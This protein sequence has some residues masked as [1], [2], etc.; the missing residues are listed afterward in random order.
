MNKI[1]KYSIL[2]YRPSYLLEE[3]VN[4][5]VLFF[6]LEDKKAVFIHPSKLRRITQFYPD[7]NLSTIRKY[8]AAFNQKVNKLNISSDIESFDSFIES[9]LLLKDASNLYFSTVKSNQ[10]IDIAK[11][12]EYYYRLYFSVYKGKTQRVKK[13]ETYLKK[14]F[15]KQLEEKL[16]GDKQRLALF[17]PK[18]SVKNTISNTEF[19]LGWQN[20]TTNL[21][22][23]LSFDLMDK[24]NFQEKSFR[25]YGELNQLKT[26]AEEQN[27]KV[28]LVL[29]KPQEKTLFEHYDNAIKVLEDIQTP[30]KIIEEHQL[31][32]YIESAIYDVKPLE[33]DYLFQS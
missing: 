33:K 6:F 27:L 13:D 15:K 5:G 23:F 11:T 26:T 10:Y 16:K 2:R 29:T 8:L 24:G 25:W 17:R 20:G 1:F 28:D 14:A 4:I 32:N 19:D 9:N 7:G 3:Q 18:P 31:N 21:V 30:K 22:K 12:I